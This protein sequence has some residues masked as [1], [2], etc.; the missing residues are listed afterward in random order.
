L[1]P[2]LATDP[3]IGGLF[4][5]AVIFWLLVEW[6]FGV[7]NRPPA[8]ATLKD[9]GSR[10][11]VVASVGIGIALA[12]NLAFAVPAASIGAPS[13]LVPLAGIALIVGGEVF[14]LYAI[15]SLGQYFT[16]VVALHPG[17][18]VVESGPYRLIRHPSYT[19]S[20]L[21]VLGICLAMANWLSLLGMI[22]AAI[23]YLYRIRIEERALVE[24][25]GEE[26]RAY[27]RRT[28]RLIPYIV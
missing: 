22:P 23:G 6:V 27:Q 12:A 17:Q 20:L 9:R 2:L 8:G 7:R 10:I 16:F 19:G 15:R 26:Y 3:L 21:T 25:L 14:R 1:I 4:W 13:R 5:A 18:H 11:V 28:K 24:G